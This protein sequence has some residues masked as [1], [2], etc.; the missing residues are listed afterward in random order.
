MLYIIRKRIDREV[1][2]AVGV[3]EQTYC[4]RC[5]KRNEE[6][7]DDVAKTKCLSII[8]D[9]IGSKLVKKYESYILQQIEYE[10]WYIR[11]AY[12]G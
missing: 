3:I 1:K 11:H 9:M 6:P 12:I 2:R 8:K 7:Q 4:H 10:V 5:R